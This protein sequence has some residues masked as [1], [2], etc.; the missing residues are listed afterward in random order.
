MLRLRVWS[1]RP[2][3]RIW[4]SYQ[5]A[6]EHLRECLPGS[7][8]QDSGLRVEAEAGAV[9]SKH[10]AWLDLGDLLGRMLYSVYTGFI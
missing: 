2:G 8:I 3:E 9:D 1:S 5:R 10:P 4:N 7:A 6:F